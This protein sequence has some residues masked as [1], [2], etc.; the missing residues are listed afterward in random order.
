LIVVAQPLSA[1]NATAAII[2]ISHLL[3]IMYPP[4]SG[5]CFISRKD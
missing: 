4:F 3:L 1:T 2:K 5:L